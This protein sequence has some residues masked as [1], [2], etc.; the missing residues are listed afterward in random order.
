MQFNFNFKSLPI[1][2]TSAILYYKDEFRSKS[3]EYFIK[4]DEFRNKNDEVCT[5]YGF[6]RLPFGA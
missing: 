6:V 2:S 3:A 4:N 5:I 1:S